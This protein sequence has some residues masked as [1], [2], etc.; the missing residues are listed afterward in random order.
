MTATDSFDPDAI[1][2]NEWTEHPLGLMQDGSS[3]GGDVQASDPWSRRFARR[4]E[5]VVGRFEVLT[6]YGYWAIDDING[7]PNEPDEPRGITVQ[8]EYVECTDP[9]D[10]GITETYSNYLYW[11]HQ[12]D[13]ITTDPRERIE[14]LSPDDFYSAME[15]VTV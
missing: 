13:D 8:V 6:F 9:N 5:D 10:P 1:S 7:N 15:Q 4:A 3:V 12:E 2:D 14:R 11:D